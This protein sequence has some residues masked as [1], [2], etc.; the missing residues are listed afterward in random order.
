PMKAVNALRRRIGGAEL[1]VA[2]GCAR[3]DLEAGN[4]AR[5]GNDVFGKSIRTCARGEGIDTSEVDYIDDY[6]TSIDVK[7]IMEDGTVKTFYY[8]DKSPTLSMRPEDLNEDYFKQAKILHLTGIFPAI[9]E[10]PMQVME[11]A[12]HLAKKHDVK[13]SFDPNI[14]LKMWSKEEA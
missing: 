7:D 3:L 8:R 14:R 11:Q 9:G 4:M 1:N 12:I 6:V 2:I 5:L 13:I 10:A